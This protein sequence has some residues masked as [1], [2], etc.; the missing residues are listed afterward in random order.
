MVFP[1]D[2]EGAFPDDPDMQDLYK[3]YLDFDCAESRNKACD[4]LQI[5]IM[6]AMSGQAPGEASIL[7]G[8]AEFIEFIAT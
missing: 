1:E 3:D 4:D 8:S 6:S 7:F 2:P 5:E